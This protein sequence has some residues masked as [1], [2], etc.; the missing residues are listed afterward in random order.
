MRLKQYLKEIDYILKLE[1]GHTLTKKTLKK[2]KKKY[3]N[4]VEDFISH[5]ETRL[6]LSKSD[7][8]RLKAAYKEI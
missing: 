8:R 5:I 6:D 2:F 4:N 7:E 3:K 1:T